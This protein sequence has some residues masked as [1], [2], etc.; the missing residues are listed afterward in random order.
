MLRQKGAANSFIGLAGLVFVLV[1]LIFVSNTLKQT[2][3]T[4]RSNAQVCTTPTLEV[5]DGID[6]NCDGMVDEGGVCSCPS[7]QT[8]CSG[9]CAN[10][11]TST[12]HCGGCGT[13][14]A[15]GTSCVSGSCVQISGMDLIISNS[16]PSFSSTGGLTLTTT[17]KNQGSLATSSSFHSVRY[18]VFEG[19]V[20]KCNTTFPQS[21]SG[22]ASGASVTYTTYFPTQI[23]SSCSGFAPVAGTRYTVI[24]SADADNFFVEANEANNSYTVTFTQPGNSPPTNTPVVTLPDLYLDKAD[25]SHTLDT[26]G[27]VVLAMKVQNKGGSTVEFGESIPE[28]KYEIKDGAV[29][30][31]SGVVVSNQINHLA[32]NSSVNITT[33]LRI[34]G[35]GD[36]TCPGGFTFTS[37]R[38]YRVTITL[39]YSS[40]SLV[41]GRLA[42]SNE[43]NNVTDYDFTYGINTTLTPIPLQMALKIS[44]GYFTLEVNPEAAESDLPLSVPVADVAGNVSVITLQWSRSLCGGC[45]GSQ[46]VLLGPTIIIGS[47]N[48]KFTL[49]APT[50]WKVNAN[51]AFVIETYPTNSPTPTNTPTPTKTPTP[52]P[53]ATPTSTPTPIPCTSDSQCTPPK[54]CDQTA[55][56]CQ[57]PLTQGM[58]VVIFN[59]VPTFSTSG[60]LTLTTTIKNQ[61]TTTIGYVGAHSVKYEVKEGTVS[62]CNATFPQGISGLT[63]G[64]HTTYAT[65]FPNQIYPSC[66]GFTP[67]SGSQYTIVITADADNIISESNENNNS[68]TITFT[69]PGNPPTSTPTPISCTSDSQCPAQHVCDTA[70]QT[71]K[72]VNATATPT[73]TPTPT[74][75]N[76]TCNSV[77]TTWYNKSISNQTSPFQI[78]FDAT[79]KVA[80]V[81]GVIGVSKG[82]ASGYANL[83]AAVRFSSA[84]LIDAR[85]GG[86]YR[87]TNASVSYG[88]NIKYHVTMMVDTSLKKYSVYV[89][90]PSGNQMTVAENFA[91]RTEQ[92]NVSSL[93]NFGGL[94][95]VSPGVE[96]CNV[97]VASPN[98]TL[99]LTPPITPGV[100][101]YK[102]EGNADCKNNNAGK[103]VDLADFEI[104]RNEYYNFCDKQNL[105][106]AKCF[107]DEDGDGSLMDANFDYPGSSTGYTDEAVKM[108]DFEIWR[109]GYFKY[110]I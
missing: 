78:E 11:S 2:T 68:F 59:S 52:S 83:A 58:D 35:S 46:A 8:N 81:N 19:S 93:D 55:H 18:Q 15:V 89:K 75:P 4:Q 10:L 3:I 82:A 13:L 66:S 12:S 36:I 7:G 30:K 48:T 42:E 90:M 22:M 50:G 71:C 101:Q 57:P 47:F 67:T 20:M 76:T 25:V 74:V 1:S 9:V 102:N 54:V 79:P 6:N 38:Q 103:P 33:P 80:N 61:G 98:T 105:T 53:T 91:F 17:L 69:Q 39:D 85:D 16:T 60:G 28:I 34:N 62:K 43:N 65:Y 108:P 56:S 37:G 5:C 29:I 95:T 44:Q 109:K 40:T 41:L 64:S 96:I 49:T 99:T 77:S 14:C 92:A 87:S 45:W 27:T 97:Q 104:W 24:L 51:N 70:T 94:S 72:P 26:S 84:G 88:P 86:S 73:F 32:S 106:A 21:A 107:S 63:G 31:C 100:C 23:Y 110:G